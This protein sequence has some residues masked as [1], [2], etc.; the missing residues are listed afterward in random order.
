MIVGSCRSSAIFPLRFGSQPA[1]GSS[2][3][4]ST[5]GT[6]YPLVVNWQ[7]L[8]PVGSNGFAGLIVP[9]FND[10]LNRQSTFLR[11]ESIFIDPEGNVF[12]LTVTEAAPAPCS[13]TGFHINSISL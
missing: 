1:I 10:K 4:G 13:R 7:E 2:G 8:T 11:H 5:C 12:A 6:P 9:P 3:I